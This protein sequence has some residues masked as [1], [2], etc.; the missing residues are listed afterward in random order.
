MTISSKG[1]YQPI[2][3]IAYAD[4]YKTAALTSDGAARDLSSASLSVVVYDKTDDTKAA[5]LIGTYSLT[6]TDA[7]NGEFDFEI[8]K[9]AF[10][11]KVGCEM[12]YSLI[13]T[14]NGRDLSH[15]YGPLIVQ[16]VY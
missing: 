12:F 14:E 3:V 8:P 11:G 9:E 10:V 6:I 4:F 7:A 5:K 2:E 13:V 15:A 16:E 1:V